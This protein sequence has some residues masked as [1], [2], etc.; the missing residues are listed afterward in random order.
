MQIYV[1]SVPAFSEN[2]LS[3]LNLRR[4]DKICKQLHYM[5]AL[6]KHANTINSQVTSFKFILV[7]LTIPHKPTNTK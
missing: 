7:Q 3:Y 5:F 1:L 6:N 4:E 2:I